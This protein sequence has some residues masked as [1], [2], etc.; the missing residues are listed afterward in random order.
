LGLIWAAA[1]AVFW[2]VSLPFKRRPLVPLVFAA[3]LTSVALVLLGWDMKIYQLYRYHLNGLVWEATFGAGALG[4]SVNLGRGTIISITIGVVSIISTQAAYLIWIRRAIVGRPFFGSLRVKIIALSILTLAVIS[5]KFAYGLDRLYNKWD[6]IRFTRAIP[7]YHPTSIKKFAITCLGYK[8]TG[9]DIWS[10]PKTG[11]LLAYPPLPG[12][13]PHPSVKSPPNILIIIPDGMRWDMVAPDVMP[14]LSR[15]ARTAWRYQNHFSNGNT[16][17]RGFFSIFYGI[18]GSYWPAFLAERKAPLMLDLMRRLGYRFR[19]I[20][21]TAFT[22]PN[23]AKTA[24]IGMD[25][26]YVDHLSGTPCQRDDLQPGE[27]FRFLDA[28]RGA[29]KPFFALMYFDATHAPYSFPPAFTRF[30]HIGDEVNFLNVTEV[31]IDTHKNR[32]KDSLFFLDSVIARTLAGL[33]KR[34]LL[35]NTVVI[36]TGD[37]GEEFFESGYYG[38]TDAFT[39]QQCRTAFIARWPGRAPR[40]VKEVTQHFDISYTLFELLGFPE[41]GQRYT[42]GSSLLHPRPRESWTINGYHSGSI[43]T[44]DRIITFNLEDKHRMDLELRDWSYKTL[45]PAQQKAELPKYRPLLTRLLE[46]QGRFFR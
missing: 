28:T 4:E 20:S 38:H 43:Y 25:D 23:L 6:Y 41:Y 16:T 35:E 26:T 15:W 33:E 11:S 36:I 8:D 42:L 39:V 27:L 9:E 37:H 1:G 14:R 46:E 3:I 22:F 44:R 24:F 19:L 30:Q 10:A 5:E 7:M 31:N 29:N 2:A 12:V 13:M 17:E 34:G 21:S 32:Y 40:T 45:P 18:H